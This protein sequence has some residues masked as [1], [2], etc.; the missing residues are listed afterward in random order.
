M[1]EQPDWTSLPWKTPGMPRE[2]QDE[3]IKCYRYLAA[4]EAAWPP[5]VM[6][7]T[8]PVCLQPDYSPGIEHVTGHSLKELQQAV[9]RV[10]L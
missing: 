3:W 9:L 1:N 4:H 8:C 7:C 6:S 10:A 5:R 2:I